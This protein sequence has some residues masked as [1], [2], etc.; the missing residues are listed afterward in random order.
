MKEDLHPRLLTR[1]EVQ[2]IVGI[3][4]SA[5][6][7][8]IAENRFPRPLRLGPKCVRWLESEIQEWVASLPRTGCRM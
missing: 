3:K 5:L 1:V 6:Y 4:H 7:Q 8:R 2:R